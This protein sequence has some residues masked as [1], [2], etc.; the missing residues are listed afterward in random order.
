MAVARPFAYNTGSTIT[1][2]DQIGDIAIGVDELNYPGGVGGVQWWNGPNETLGYIITKAVPDGS[3]PNPLNIPSYIGF[4]RSKELTESSFVTLVNG[5]FKQT[6]T[7]GAQCAIYLNNN[8]YWTSWGN[9]LFTPTPTPT[10][11]L[12]P[13]PSITPTL[14]ITPTIT[15]SITPTRTLTPT[16]TITPT[17]TVTPTRTL[18]P[19]PT[20]T[21]T[22]TI[23]PTPT[24]TPVIYDPDAQAFITAAD[25]T[26]IT[27]KNAINT[28][29]VGLKSD[30]LWTKMSAIYPFVGGTASSHKFNLKDPRDTDDAYRIAFYGGWTHDAN[31]IAGNGTNSYADTFAKYQVF[32]VPYAIPRS[33]NHWSTYQTTI[34]TTG[35]YNGIQEPGVF[36]GFSTVFG[37]YVGLQQFAVGATESVGFWN[38]TVTSQL[39]GV[40][41][42]NG[43]SVYT[44]S[45][46]FDLSN[47]VSYIIG[48]ARFN[49]NISGS[50]NTRFAFSSVGFG[51]TS[52]NAANFNTRVQA[53][54]T[55]LGRQV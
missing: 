52:T 46:A 22:K 34:G 40:L 26:N 41:Y 23:T 15:P 9:L 51:L 44:I 24:S 32:T 35:S 55:A 30:G 25:I 4:Y 1:G 45:Q 48:A 6:F 39:S 54:Q 27:Q 31:G 33:N 21:P 8:G 42:K 3:Q 37:K 28:L 17:N 49:G 38:G 36:F 20:I 53:F 43:A 10:I 50:N 5:V 7:T 16:P 14:S 47:S 2:T 11:T 29:V 13:T 18:T 19:T 12:T